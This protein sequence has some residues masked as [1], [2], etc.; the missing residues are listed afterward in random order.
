MAAEVQLHV[1][2]AGTQ[3]KTFSF[4]E[5]GTVVVGRAS[6]CGIEVPAGERQVSRRHCAFDIDPPALRVR[7]LGSRNGTYVNGVRIDGPSS[8]AHQ[9]ADGDEVRVGT[10]LL[11]VSSTA[12]GLP[13]PTGGDT[14]GDAAEQI[15][16]YAIVRELGRGA[17]GIV[18]L[19]RQQDSGESLALKVFQPETGIHPGAVNGFLREIRN[20]EALRHPNLV[21]FRNAGSTGMLLFFACEYCEGGN[22]AQRV[23]EQDGPLCP[24]DAVALTRQV[25]DGLAYA[26]SALLPAVRLGDGTTAPASG[27]VHR[28]VK[29]QNI[30]LSGTGPA[31]VVKIADFGLA[32]AFEHAGLSDYT[33]TGALG[34]SVAFMAR[35]QIVNYKYAKP[36]VDVWASAACLYWALTRSTPRDF[37]DGTD[38]LRVVLREPAV[39]IRNRNASLP[40]RLA[41]LIDDILAVEDPRES[42]TP[43]AEEFNRALEEAM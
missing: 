43:S 11:R 14:E 40:V 5:P 6:D 16:R 15:D 12:E 17:Q 26:H 37:P 38:P 20:T 9:L 18:Y 27:L 33:R 2:V 31:P 4:G 8:H 42:V 23:I 41:A 34:G 19:V 13:A 24:D 22:L 28:D 29:P 1:T 3:S 32:K 25:L 35:A 30:L 21:R 39:P 36:A 7:D 10:L